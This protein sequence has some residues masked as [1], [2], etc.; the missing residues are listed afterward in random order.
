MDPV[1]LIVPFFPVIGMALVVIILAGI[2]KGLAQR[3]G[4]KPY[5][6]ATLR[7]Y[8]LVNSITNKSER[9]MVEALRRR[10]GDRYRICPKVRMEDVISVK[11]NAGDFKHRQSLR[12]RVKS[13]HFDAV[14]TT[15]SG[16]PVAA[17]EY[18]GPTH[19]CRNQRKAD[20]FKNEVCEAVGLVIVRIDYRRP[21]DEQIARLAL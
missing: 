21:I 7:G 14:I 15:P 11:R 8:Q 2:V 17:I 19:G 4:P 6:E 1:D 5:S 12:G 3:G 9:E 13:R 10:F 18:D 20:G 16:K